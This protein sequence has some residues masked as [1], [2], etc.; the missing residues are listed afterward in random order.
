ME[1]TEIQTYTEGGAGRK[2]CPSCGKYVGA[3]RELCA[4]GYE[5]VEGALERFQKVEDTKEI[6]TYDEPGKGRKQCQGCKKYVGL[7]IA[8]CPCGFD[9]STVV[10]ESQVVTYDEPGKGR[11]QCQGCKKYVG[12]RMAI[13]PCGF[14]FSKAVKESQVVTYDEGGPRRKQCPTCEKYVGCSQSHC[15]CGYE[16]PLQEERMV[17]EEITKVEVEAQASSNACGWSGRINLTPAGDCAVRLKGSSYEEVKDW[18]TAV[19]EN[20]HRHGVHYAPSA[21][22]YY[23]RQFIPIF[24]QGYN[25]AIEHLSIIQTEML[26]QEASYEFN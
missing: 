23:V 20:G 10:K 19:V 17:R 21:L 24:T 15:A 12:L 14:D 18:A 13:C 7:R 4:C 8:I 9:F 3:R 16:F 2:V 25:E 5:F 6:S 1:L 26:N 22:R 11:K